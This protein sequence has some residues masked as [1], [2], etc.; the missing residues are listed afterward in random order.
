MGR[1]QLLSYPN[2]NLW[3]STP[4]PTGST[5]QAWHHLRQGDCMED[6]LEESKTEC[7]SSAGCAGRGLLYKRRSSS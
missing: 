4:V 2:P 7:L 3:P 6:K 1:S 5:W